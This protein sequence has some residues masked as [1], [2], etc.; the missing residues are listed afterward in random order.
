[1]DPA[2]LLI[3]LS[4]EVEFSSDPNYTH[5]F[6]VVGLTSKSYALLFY[7]GNATEE[8]DMYYAGGPLQARYATVTANVVTLSAT[9]TLSGADAMPIFQ[10]ASTRISSTSA[11][12]VFADYN[13]NFGINTQLIYVKNGLIG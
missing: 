13:H 5:Y 1:M 10:L 7:N 8:V 3:T 2:T 12:V 9:S 4:P 6:D 11:V